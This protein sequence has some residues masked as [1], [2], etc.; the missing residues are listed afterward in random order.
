[1]VRPKLENGRTT[2]FKMRCTEQE[3]QALSDCA[4][5]L[6]TDIAKLVR[7]IPD[8]EVKELLSSKLK[9]AGLGKR[10]R[11]PTSATS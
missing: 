1:M 6:G 10:R 2:T 3:R 4:E 5:E 11:S 9:A 7:L 8:P